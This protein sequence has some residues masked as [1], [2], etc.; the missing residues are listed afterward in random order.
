MNRILQLML[1]KINYILKDLAIIIGKAINQKN[2]LIAKKHMIA[3]D[4]IFILQRE[5]DGQKKIVSLP[6]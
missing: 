3:A 4:K 6:M 5:M 2:G 1:M